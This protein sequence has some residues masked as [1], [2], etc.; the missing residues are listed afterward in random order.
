[1]FNPGKTH[2]YFNEGKA[3]SSNGAVVL[4]KT[5]NSK[6]FGF[7]KFVASGLIVASISVLSL[8]AGFVL[9][10]NADENPISSP[11]S[12]EESPQPSDSAS[13]ITAPEVTPTPSSQPSNNGGNGSGNGGGGSSNAGG[14]SS[15]SSCNNEAPYAP[16]IIS[17]TSA[18]KN[19]ITLYWGKPV[20]GDVTHYSISYGLMKGKPLYGVNNIGN[21]TSYTVRGLSAGVTYY[22]SVNAVNGCTAGPASNEIGI[23]GGGKFINAP[24]VGFKSAVVNGKSTQVTQFKGTNTNPVVKIVESPKPVNIKF[25]AGNSLN[26]GLLGKA[27]SF[28]KGLFN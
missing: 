2:I 20:H 21:V 25:E 18:K 26:P 7:R 16:K 5:S 24:A 28:F 6:E 12:T 23:K 13:P 27:V 15:S 1:M 8:Q 3:A 17:A 11:I 22:F 9:S 19:E 10:A 14:G 4:V